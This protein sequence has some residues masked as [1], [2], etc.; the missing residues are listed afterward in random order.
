MYQV[1]RDEEGFSRQVRQVEACRYASQENE[2]DFYTWRWTASLSF[3]LSSSNVSSY[4][5]NYLLISVQSDHMDLI[6]FSRRSQ[7]KGVQVADY[8]LTRRVALQNALLFPC[9]VIWAKSLDL[10][11]SFSY[12]C[13][14]RELIFILSDLSNC[15]ANLVNKI[16]ET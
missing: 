11:L 8:T 6:L 16:C 2:T 12:F 14:K 15:S 5:Q 13:T 7:L 4:H 10:S 9:H 3:S 1:L